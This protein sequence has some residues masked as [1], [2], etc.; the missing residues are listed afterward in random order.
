[1]KVISLEKVEKKK[2]HMEGAVGA[3]KQL[4]LGSEDGAPTY[5]FR[6]F[7]VEP[8]GNTPF[9]NHPYEHMNYVIEGEGTLVNENG[10]ET[11][12][13]AGDFALVEPDE[14]HQ[15]RNT[16]T[17]SFIMICGVPKEFE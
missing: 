10:E 2:V 1:M 4:P 14:K 16:G 17:K 3:W 12:L 5:S 9:H 8:G 15:Y 13:K 7:T 6:V 11:F